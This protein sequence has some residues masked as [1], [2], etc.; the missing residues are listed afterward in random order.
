MHCKL[1]EYDFDVEYIQGPTNTVADYL[2]RAPET[3]VECEDGT[4]ERLTCG[5]L[6][7]C[8]SE[9]PAFATKQSDFDSIVCDVRTLVDLITWRSA[10][11]ATVVCTCAV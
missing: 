7:H 9:W 11:G 10:L 5:G 8:G 1:Q 6:V 4:R 2:S 3:T